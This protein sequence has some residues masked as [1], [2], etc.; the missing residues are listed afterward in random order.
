MTFDYYTICIKFN[1]TIDD[2]AH[3]FKKIKAVL[4]D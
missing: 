2:D 1:H 3:P 4:N